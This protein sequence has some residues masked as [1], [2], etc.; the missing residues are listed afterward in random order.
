MFGKRGCRVTLVPLLPAI[1]TLAQTKFLINYQHTHI[2]DN[3]KL[4]RSVAC[5]DLKPRTFNSS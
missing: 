4:I 3:T 2:H 1:H 5:G